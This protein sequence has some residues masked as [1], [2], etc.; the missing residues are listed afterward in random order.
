[1]VVLTNRGLHGQA[2]ELLGT[3]IIRGDYQPG[4]VLDPVEVEHELD[5]SRTVVRE[6]LRVLAAKGLVGAK[7]KR[8]TFVRPQ[9]DWSLLDPEV[10]QWQFDAAANGDIMRDLIEVRGMIE[11]S[12]AAAAAERRTDDDVKELQAAL[13]AMS[14]ADDDAEAL[15][16]A[17]VRFH[18]ALLAASHNKL[19]SRMSVVIEVG[20][21]ARD[22]LVHSAP[23]WTDPVPLHEAVFTAVRRR[24]PRKAH[25][26]M[27]SLL[28]AAG[29]AL[30]IEA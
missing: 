17:D 25:T 30:S 29:E 15:T 5:V 21:R 14:E 4:E 23:T 26:A 22:V 27:L 9:S 19:L 8:G 16:A 10:L 7:P 20:L 11:P 3:R 24:Q 6:A 1:M 2:V 12:A 18:S 13:T 28:N